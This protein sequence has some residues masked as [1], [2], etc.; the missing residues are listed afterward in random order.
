M[1]SGGFVDLRQRFTASE[2]E[3]H[4]AA[5]KL[6]PLRY[7]QSLDGVLSFPACPERL[8][9]GSMSYPVQKQAAG[10][11]SCWAAV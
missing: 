11:T 10:L 7:S 3:H 9:P 6:F 5:Q 1:F 2:A 8:A 4:K